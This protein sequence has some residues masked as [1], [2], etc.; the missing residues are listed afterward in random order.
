MDVGEH[1][2]DLDNSG[3]NMLRAKYDMRK[4]GRLAGGVTRIN[5]TIPTYLLGE[6]DNWSG[7]RSLFITFMV[8]EYMARNGILPK[9]YP[10]LNVLY[11]F[12]H[13]MD[14]FAQRVKDAGGRNKETDRDMRAYKTYM[15]QFTRA[16]RRQMKK[17]CG[18]AVAA[19]KMRT[20]IPEPKRRLRPDLRRLT[21]AESKQELGPEAYPDIEDK[22]ELYRTNRSLFKQTFPDLYAEW[23]AQDEN[24]AEDDRQDPT[25]AEED[26]DDP[27]EDPVTN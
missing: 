20:V 23:R 6:I 15:R 5:L 9:G 27:P 12:I 18:V 16:I 4:L 22:R 3:M 26:G 24:K 11:R 21:D 25:A 10:R 19:E 7:S 17:M 8:E 2:V 14:K 1:F 13:A